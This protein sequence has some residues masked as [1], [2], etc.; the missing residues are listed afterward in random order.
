[1]SKNLLIFILIGVF[2]VLIDYSIYKLLIE[3]DFNITFSKI[4]SSIVSVLVNYILNSK[5]NFQNKKFGF[6]YAF[7]YC[8]V[9]AVLILF[10]ALFNYV[11]FMILNNLNYA[12]IVATLLSTFLNY[13]SVKL[14]FRRINNDR[15][16]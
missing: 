2:C 9:Y 8:L 16:N 6:I 14:F 11:S 7:F 10:N 3:F 1:M 5:Y 4:A 15:K 13:F 12:F